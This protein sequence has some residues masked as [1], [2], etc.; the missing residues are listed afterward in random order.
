[1]SVVIFLAFL[2]F[3]PPNSHT[4]GTQTNATYIQENRWKDAP[5]V[6]PPI[7]INPL[8][9]F[10]TADPYLP[11]SQKNILNTIPKQLWVSWTGTKYVVGYRCCNPHLFNKAQMCGFVPHNGFWMYKHAISLMSGT[12][13]PTATPLKALPSLHVLRITFCPFPPIIFPP[14]LRK[15]R[16]EGLG[17]SHVTKGCLSMGRGGGCGSKACWGP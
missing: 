12:R 8:C 2:I 4:F 9:K 7:F 13:K 1:M 17:L 11:N 5:A 15:H 6:P 3:L 14:L 10:L 16:G